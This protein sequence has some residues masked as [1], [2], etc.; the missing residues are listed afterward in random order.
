MNQ[1]TIKVVENTLEIYPHG[2]NEP[3]VVK[4]MK[5]GW[6]GRYHVITEWGDTGETTHKLMKS[7]EI[8]NLYN[9]DGNDL[10]IN[11]VLSITKEEILE[12]PNDSD[13]GELIRKKLYL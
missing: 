5:S 8:L 6:N 13:L 12:N 4:I 9:I 11:D 2:Q 7:I 1:S 10:P 3:F